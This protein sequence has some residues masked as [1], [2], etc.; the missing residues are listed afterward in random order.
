MYVARIWYRS[1]LNLIYPMRCVICGED[2]DPEGAL[3]LCPEHRRRIHFIEESFCSI[4]GKKLY[5][6]PEDD[7]IC[8]NCRETKRYFDLGYT[9]AIYEEIIQTMIHDF[10]YKG[11]EFLKYPL[12]QMV[13]DGIFRH[14]N[15]RDIDI[16]IPVPLHWRRYM[17]RRFNQ[18]LELARLTSKKL[19]IPI[20]KRN[21][22]RIRYTTPQVYISP[23]E[24]LTNIKGAFQ[25]MDAGALRG[26]RVMLVDDVLTT[27]ATLNECARV[28]KKAKVKEITVVTLAQSE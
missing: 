2:L 17:H 6:L 28:L 9:T 1:V 7:L 21:L 15:Y 11:K 5:T 18:A 10:K 14:V 16:I 25:V 3:Y 20:V 8:S 27:G 26:K 23:E 12:R 19:D 4:C 13:Y 22:R 24:R